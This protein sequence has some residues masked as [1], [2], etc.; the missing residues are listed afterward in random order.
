MEITASIIAIIAVSFLIGLFIA[1]GFLLAGARIAGIENR[2]FGK[3]VGAVI[4]GSKVGVIL[5]LVLAAVP[6][7]GP[8]IS[9]LG[10]FIAQSL[11]MMGIFNTTFGKALIA[12]IL[13]WLLTFVVAGA[14]ILIIVMLGG[15]AF[16]P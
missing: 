5:S 9:C 10:G 12:S 13:S 1:T 2:S 14:I 11:V 6:I 8:A 3:A 15:L 16:L 4:L 7:I